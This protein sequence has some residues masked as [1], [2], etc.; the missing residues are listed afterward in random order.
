MKI[1][2][3]LLVMLVVGLSALALPVPVHAASGPLLLCERRCDRI[4]QR[5]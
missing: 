4:Q 5:Q 2:T 3:L 1:N